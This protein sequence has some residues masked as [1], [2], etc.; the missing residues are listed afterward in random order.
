[1]TIQEN[2]MPTLS[3]DAPTV[4]AFDAHGI[5]YVRCRYCHRWHA[6][7]PVEGLT[8]AACRY[9]TPYVATGYKLVLAGQMTPE[10][11][12]QY[13]DE[14]AP[15][16][17][18]MKP[19]FEPEE[20]GPD[21]DGLNW[22]ISPRWTEGERLIKDPAVDPNSTLAMA[23]GEVDGRVIM[24]WLLSEAQ[25]CNATIKHASGEDYCEDMASLRFD[26]GTVPA[27]P[28][29]F[30]F[31]NA[32]KHLSRML[33]DGR[34]PTEPVSFVSEVPVTVFLAPARP[35]GLG[36]LELIIRTRLGAD[37]TVREHGTDSII[38]DGRRDFSD[39]QQVTLEIGDMFTLRQVADLFIRVGNLYLP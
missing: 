10:L 38:A 11:M 39:V 23:L 22:C 1:M 18:V 27:E 14:T 19:P 25:W 2:I 34:L 35:G 30:V 20:G 8:F 15:W 36:G 9:D 12:A 26:F 29:A 16:T 37:L 28:V 32:G 4:P 6:H 7:E 17:G 5:W 31:Q 33:S 3:L 24:H 21:F 13:P